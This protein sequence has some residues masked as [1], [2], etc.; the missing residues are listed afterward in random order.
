MLHVIRLHDDAERNGRNNLT[1]Q[2]PL[3]I[4]RS[5]LVHIKRKTGVVYDIT[6]SSCTPVQMLRSLNKSEQWKQTTS[7]VY[8]DQ[9]KTGDSIDQGPDILYKQCVRT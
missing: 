7:A 1:T 8:E 3:N 5:R 2:R 6:C 9:T 4:L